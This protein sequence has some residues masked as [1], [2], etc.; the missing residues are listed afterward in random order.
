MTN[1]FTLF[2]KVGAHDRW[3]PASQYV[4]KEHA[5]RIAQGYSCAT[6]VEERP[7]NPRRQVMTRRGWRSVGLVLHHEKKDT[8]IVLQLKEAYKAAHRDD[9]VR[10]APLSECI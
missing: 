2:F 10:A 1:V 7:Y 6:K 8:P 3:T 5:L 4:T 9:V